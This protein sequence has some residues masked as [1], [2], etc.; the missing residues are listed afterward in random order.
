MIAAGATARNSPDRCRQTDFNKVSRETGGS[1]VTQLLP[2]NRPPNEPW[3]VYDN[4]EALRQQ[5]KP[6]LHALI[7]GVSAYPNLPDAGEPLTEAGL[8]MRKISSTSLTAFLMVDWLIRADQAGRLTHPLATCRLLLSPAAGEVAASATVGPNGAA[9]IADLNA[10]GCTLMN[11]VAAGAAWREDAA[12]RPDG[13]TLFYFAG[14]GIQRS[15]GDQVLLLE[16]FGG[17][18]PLALHAVD[19]NTLRYGMAPTAKR[20]E[21]ARTQFYFVDAC[22]NLPS[23]IL[24]YQELVVTP[25]FDVEASGMDDRRAPI[26]FAALPDGKAQ[27]VP[28]EQTLFSMALMR[29]LGG[30]AGIAPEDDAEGAAASRWHVSYQSLSQALTDTLADLNRRYGGDQR[31]IGDGFGDDAVLCYLDGPPTIPI[32]IMVEPDDALRCTQLTLL[33]HANPAT[34]FEFAQPPKEHPFEQNLTAGYYQMVAT[35]QPPT[36]PYQSRLAELRLVS[37]LQPRLWKVKMV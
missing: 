18:G 31:W 13:A 26:F 15:R 28:G 7:A 32:R 34:K 35:V 1:S 27:A 36:P 19:I 5:G 2:A 16:S 21:I 9:R 11:L 17:P 30:E 6:G 23:R 20:P 37:P 12:Q 33:E 8:G 24:S 10:P 3:L 14:H 29:C 4:R 22:R 25:V